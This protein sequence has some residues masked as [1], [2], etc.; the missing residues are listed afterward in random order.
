M[1]ESSFVIVVESTLPASDGYTTM[2]IIS[3]YQI[4][5]TTVALMS[6]EDTSTTSKMEPITISDIITG[7]RL[8]T[9]MFGVQKTTTIKQ[10]TAMSPESVT[11]SGQ[12]R[13]ITTLTSAGRQTTATNSLTVTVLPTFMTRS[14]TPSVLITTEESQTR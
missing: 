5:P 3:T 7:T 12:T 14:L 1:V 10:T 9:T 11:F 13:V 2:D 4:I 6:S 8:L